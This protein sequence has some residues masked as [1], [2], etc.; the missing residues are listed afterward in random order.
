M[1][2]RVA[3]TG[4]A[5]SSVAP[6]GMRATVSTTY[7]AAAQRDAQ[8]TASHEAPAAASPGRRALERVA[9][10]ARSHQQPEGYW[11]GTLSSSALATAIAMVALKL[12]NAEHYHD[13]IRGGRAWL[14]RT[15]RE[16]GGWGDAL[17]DE[18]NINAT[19]LAIA[20]LTFTQADDSATDDGDALRRADRALGR[21][22]GYAAVGD[23]NR[24]TLSGPCRTVAALAGIMDWRKIK[25]LRPEVILLPRSVRRTISTT[26][27]AYLSISM[28]HA[29][30]VPQP[31]NNLPTYRRAV[32]ASISWLARA[33]GPNGSFEESAFLSSVIIMGMVASRH[34]DLPWLPAAI[35]FVARS[36][37]EDGG[38]P[39]D[40]DL[41]TF[42]TALSIFAFRELDGQVPRAEVLREWL[43]GRQ[44]QDV[45][46]PT[47]AQPGGWAWAMPA[48][49][50][51]TDDTSYTLLALLSLEAPAHGAQLRR[52][53]RW[54]ER[55][56][57]HDGSW[58]TFVR[59][60]SMPFDH[61]C[62]YIV[63]HVLCAL[64]ACGRLIQQPRILERALA[65]LTRAQRYDGSFGSV[66]FREATAGT[67]S[68]LEALAD[69]GL[70]HAPMAQRAR[71]HLLRSQ[72]DDGGWA[73]L[74]GQPS[75]AEET[76][77]ALLALLRFPLDD[78]AR[79]AV[80]RGVAW[81]AVHQRAD[82]TWEDAPIGLYYSAMWYSD[83]TYAV[84]L[85]MRALAR[86]N[87]N[88]LL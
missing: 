63:G 1:I 81:L 3:E 52:G 31:L 74:R 70:A 88:D 79:A 78:T 36:Q 47:G 87:A 67:A 27:P 15:Q 51:E 59:N 23:P 43:L 40:R 62:P 68:V 80:R 53:V 6:K 61:A 38:W 11:V 86:A 13:A 73:G 17:S 82:G 65:Y 85:P 5:G 9:D 77:W 55:M 20:A 30:R 50:P 35:D 66:W 72:N 33:Q 42:D 14:L 37:R 57:N 56:Q 2:D 39:I 32:E 19:S 22:G 48:G 64:Q 84:A 26:F 7:N 46:F 58:S 12:V 44:F 69:C 24:C 28:L 18:S 54:L 60:S 45:C 25:L 21:F 4:H 10:Y 8:A 75:T 29:S 16:D 71:G 34:G 76:A 83:S 41:E 49:W